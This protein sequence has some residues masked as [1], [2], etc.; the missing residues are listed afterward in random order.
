MN[1]NPPGSPVHEILQARILE[2][3]AIFSSRGIFPTQ[4]SNLSLLHLLHW[5]A[6]SLPLVPSRMLG[7][8]MA[9]QTSHQEHNKRHLYCFHHLGNS[10]DFRSSIPLMQMKTRCIFLIINHNITQLTSFSQNKYSV[11][12]K[13]K[14]IPA[15]L[16]F[17]DI[18]DFID[19]CFSI[20]VLK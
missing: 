14:T 4:G 20:L 8:P 15:H 6:G 5:Q 11:P 19:S 18:Q 10:K 1:C 13:K 12:L 3:V 2:W 7:Y 17:I 16:H 9:F